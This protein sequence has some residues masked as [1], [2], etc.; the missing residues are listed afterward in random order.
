MRFIG[1]V[2]GKFDQYLDI[3]QNVSESIQVGDFGAGFKPLPTVIGETG[4][5][6]TTKHKFI[7][8]NHDNPAICA[9]SPNWIHD[10]DV[11]APMMFVGGALSIDRL[12]RFEGRDWWSDEE[13]SMDAFYRFMDIYEAIK[14]EIMV[15]HDCPEVVSDKLFGGTK[16]EMPSRTRQA[17]QAIFDLHQPKLWIFG[18]WHMSRNEMIDGT[19]FIC[20]GELEYKDIE[21]C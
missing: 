6:A 21:L 12:K 13:C 16:L 5:F 20:L 11:I 18:H 14:P 3:I 4:L 19:R 7:R 15:T 17:L 1:D 10:G 8:G 2:H 9:E